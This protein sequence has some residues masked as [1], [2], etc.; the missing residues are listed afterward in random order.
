MLAALLGGAPA[1]SYLGQKLQF[2][3]QTAIYTGA[4]YSGV[5][6]DDT[7]F[8]IVVVP[9]VGV[10]L[11]EAEAALDETLAAF[12]E[13]GVDSEQFERLKRQIYASEIFARDSTRGLAQ[14]YGAALTSGLTVADVQAWPDILQSITPE[15]ILVAGRR[16]LDRDKAVTG[17]LMQPTEEVSQ[18]S[19]YL[20]F[21]FWSPQA[22]YERL[23]TFK[24]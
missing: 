20:S 2:D 24:K 9:A 5:A 22:L 4:G 8:G 11:A 1:T 6:L 12:L 3:S 19:A 21:S 10:S 14:R 17:W 7:T 23:S 18:R 16:V 13:E 15:E